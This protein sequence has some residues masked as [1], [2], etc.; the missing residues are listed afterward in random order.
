M[1]FSSRNRI[2]PAVLF[3]FHQL[4]T[5]EASAETQ[6]KLPW[7]LRI[8]ERF[9]DHPQ[10]IEL[11][12]LPNEFAIPKIRD[13]FMRQFLVH[14]EMFSYPMELSMNLYSKKSSVKTLHTTEH[15]PTGESMK[16]TAVSNI[17]RSIS[18]KYFVKKQIE[19]F[20]LGVRVINVC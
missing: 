10:M 16:R 6:Q 14:D 4:K 17:I 11:S 7:R 5:R 9:P 2:R 19:F 3:F 12:R 8:F 15:R 20:S 13:S 1:I 18:F